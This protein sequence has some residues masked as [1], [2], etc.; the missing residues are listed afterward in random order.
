MRIFERDNHDYIELSSKRYIPKSFG[1]VSGG[2]V[3]QVIMQDQPE[4]GVKIL[5]IMLS[6]LAFYESARK[7][8]KRIIRC[9]G[10]KSIYE[11]IYDLL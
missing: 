11:R 10:K 4:G 3:W 6:G 9:H 1:G 5:E 8:D 7:N 2:G